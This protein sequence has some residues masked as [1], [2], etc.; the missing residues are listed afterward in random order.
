M[1]LQF[2]LAGDAPA[3][4]SLWVSVLFHGLRLCVAHCLSSWLG[5]EMNSTGHSG[6]G[7]EMTRSVSPAYLALYAVIGSVT[8]REFICL[9]L[10]GLYNW[11]GIEVG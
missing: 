6:Q 1:R 2:G 11:A 3:N 9:E 10:F 4:V 5:G 8:L 7:P